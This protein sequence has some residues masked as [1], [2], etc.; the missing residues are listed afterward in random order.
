MKLVKEHLTF[1][2]NYLI[3]TRDQVKHKPDRI[4]KAQK[5]I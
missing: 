3:S 1:M 4:F 2:V 5:I